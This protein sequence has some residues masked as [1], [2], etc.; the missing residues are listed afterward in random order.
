MVII[1]AM[2]LLM[3][4]SVFARYSGLFV[5]IWAN[6]LIDQL[7]LW[8]AMFG[9]SIA[10]RDHAHFRLTLVLEHVSRRTGTMLTRASDL[11]LLAL[12]LAMIVLGVRLVLLASGE[13]TPVLGIPKALVHTAI[14]I[15]GILFVIYTG[16]HLASDLCG[17]CPPRR[18]T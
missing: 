5:V 7:F 2:A 13:K 12:G 1:A 6:E 8:L 14:P 18:E 16:F 9:A 15:S 4:L 3:G 17:R 11:S 10:V